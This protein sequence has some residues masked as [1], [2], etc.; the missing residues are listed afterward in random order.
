MLVVHFVISV[1]IVYS[2][3]TVIEY[4]RK[5]LIEKYVFAKVLAYIN[6]GVEKIYKKLNICIEKIVV[7]I[8]KL[9]RRNLWVSLKFKNPVAIC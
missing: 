2:A 5:Y 7:K 3:C 8:D 4:V 6:A 9:N 1:I